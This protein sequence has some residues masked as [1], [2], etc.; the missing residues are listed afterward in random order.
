MSL[1]QPYVAA[2]GVGALFVLIYLES[3]GAPVPGETAVIAASALAAE[4][5]LSLPH[6]LIAIFCGAVLG[7]STGYA[8]GRFGGHK[9]L[10]TYGP[11]FKLTA[12]RLA[13]LE[14]LF[15]KRGIYIVL[16]A[17]FVVVLRQLNGVI[18]GSVRMPWF[19]FL[20]ANVAG[21]LLWTIAWGAGPYFVI[22]VVQ[23]LIGQWRW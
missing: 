21:A 16:T 3:L 6:A 20:P 11:R 13:S 17:R 1:I 9:L 2:Y 12:E 7:D 4:G 19:H 15:Q 23:P 10:T 8:I 14:A 22:H 18:A 5:Q